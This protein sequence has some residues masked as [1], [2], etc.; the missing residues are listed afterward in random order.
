MIPTPIFSLENLRVKDQSST[1]ILPYP[2]KSKP[3]HR[4]FIKG[5]IPYIWISKANA[6][7]GSTGVIATGLWFYVGLKKSKRFKIDH[8]L[9]KLSGVSRQTRQ[10]ALIKLERAGLIR[11]TN[12]AGNY[13]T[14]EILQ[15]A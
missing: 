5:P 11:L 13:P 3:K 2:I 10:S 6:L 15:D 7:G 1:T 4:L 12:K 14:V 8:Q 9:D